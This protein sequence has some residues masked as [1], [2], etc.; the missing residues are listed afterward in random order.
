MFKFF[1]FARFSL[2][3]LRAVVKPQCKAPMKWEDCKWA[4]I[5]V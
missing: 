4:G 3:L 2:D 5:E 1:V